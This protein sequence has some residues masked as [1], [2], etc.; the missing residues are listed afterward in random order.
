MSGSSTTGVSSK[1]MDRHS[2]SKLRCIYYAVFILIICAFILLSI[3]NYGFFLF[4]SV[5]VIGLRFAWQVDALGMNEEK[6]LITVM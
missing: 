4:V 3:D 6:L 2:T 5:R 1:H